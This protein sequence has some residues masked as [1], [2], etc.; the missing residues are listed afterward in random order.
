M[1]IFCLTSTK[2]RAVNH[3]CLEI[4]R[5]DVKG[6]IDYVLNVSH[7]KSFVKKKMHKKDVLEL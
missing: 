6:M 3:P 5:I 4:L 2:F 7:M 1:L